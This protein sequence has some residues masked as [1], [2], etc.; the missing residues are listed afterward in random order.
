[1]KRLTGILALLSVILYATG[2]WICE[3]FYADDIIRWRF[4]RDTLTGF[5]IAVLVLLHFL[6]GSK[7]KTASLSAFGVFC[8]GNLFDRLIFNIGEFVWSDYFMI[9]AATWVFQHKLRANVSKSG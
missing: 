8:F 6:P 4:L 3:Y 7:L 9:I 1:M 5:V 2:Y